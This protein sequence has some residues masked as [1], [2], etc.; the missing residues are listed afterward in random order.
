MMLFSVALCP[1]CKYF[2]QLASPCLV[3][4]SSPGHLKGKSAPD[5]EMY[6]AD[7]HPENP[8]IRQVK[9]AKIIA[10]EDS[11]QRAD[12]ANPRKGPCH[13][14]FLEIGNRRPGWQ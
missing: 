3:C 7:E 6:D 5:M 14:A 11:H 9:D 8:E 10:E 4:L 1:L 12:D 13:A 2:I